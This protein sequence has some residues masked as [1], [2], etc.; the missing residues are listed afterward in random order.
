MKKNIFAALL[1]SLLLVPAIKGNS[2]INIEKQLGEVPIM[3][4][5][6][7]DYYLHD[8]SNFQG[9]S[10]LVSYNTGAKVLDK[11]QLSIGFHLGTSLLPYTKAPLHFSNNFEINGDD[12]NL[13]FDG[14]NL[15]G[16]SQG[17][18]I[19]FRF[20][21]EATG[22]PVYDPFTGEKIGFGIPILSGIGTGLAFSPSLIPK[23]S[24]GIG[25]GTE[26]SVGIL[27]GAL[28]SLG[29]SLTNEFEMS[30]DL[31]YS[32][33][34]KHD[35]FNW[36]PVLKEQNYHLSLSATYISFALGLSTKA[37][38]GF[39]ENTESPYFTI[40]DQLKGVD[41]NSTGL[42]FELMASKKFGFFEI[43]AFTSSN[44]TSYSIKSQGDVVIDINSSFNENQ[45]VRSQ[46]TVSDLI[47][48]ENNFSSLMVGGAAKFHFDGFG[49]G[50]KYGRARG[51]DF[52]STGINYAF[53]LVKK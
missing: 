26:I 23:L 48:V 40:D 19:F 4:S 36:I 3:L 44:Q 14:P 27:P 21:D 28:K 7:F 51:A 13:Y 37:E 22:A 35:I 42:G 9:E 39:F 12:P 31:M 30:K 15:F 6:Y 32:V 18:T 25:F 50:I 41:Y 53:N 17:G 47:S 34:V 20:I 38:S 29:N 5:E 52:F 49:W 43:S 33:G 2:Q 45:D 11:W 16:N 8:F 24:M 10:Y 46:Y 1:V